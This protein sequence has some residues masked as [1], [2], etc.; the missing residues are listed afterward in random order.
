MGSHRVGHDW[1]DLAAAAA[2]SKWSKVKWKSLSCVWFFVISWTV[3]LQAPLSME[4]SRQE[5]WSGLPFPFPG[6]LPDPGIE[7]GPLAFQADSLPSEPQGKSNEVNWDINIS[8]ENAFRLSAWHTSSIAH[9]SHPQWLPRPHPWG[10]RQ[11]Q[12][13][14]GK[15]KKSRN[16]FSSHCFPSRAQ[17]LAGFPLCYD[18]PLL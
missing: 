18:F 4:F 7:P 17:G 10:E 8:G 16:L 9:Y 14:R 15:R 11:E 6:G 12:G 13:P 1:S 3:A 5:Y 2:A